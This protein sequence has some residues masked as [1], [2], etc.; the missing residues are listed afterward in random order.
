MGA[1]APEQAA[2]GGCRH[3]AVDLPVTQQRRRIRVRRA[4]QEV[5]GARVLNHLA[6]VQAHQPLAV[7]GDHDR[8]AALQRIADYVERFQPLP[9]RLVWLSIPAQ[10]EDVI[11]T[12]HLIV[13]EYHDVID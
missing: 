11:D 9:V 8:E 1:A 7:A 6:R 13:G 3:K 5:V 2:L 4:L 10:H 12:Q